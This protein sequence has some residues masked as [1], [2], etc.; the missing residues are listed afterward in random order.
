M[1]SEV[2]I[3]ESFDTAQAAVEYSWRN[4]VLPKVAL[5]SYGQAATRR[6]QTLWTRHREL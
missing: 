1:H 5:Q 3:V 6:R 4:A 2:V